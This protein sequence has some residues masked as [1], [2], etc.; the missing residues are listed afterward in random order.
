MASRFRWTRCR[1]NLNR[2]STNLDNL[3]YDSYLDPPKIVICIFAVQLQCISAGSVRLSHSGTIL[4][5]QTGMFVSARP[6]KVV[7]MRSANVHELPSTERRRKASPPPA[8]R[9]PP[10]SR[11]A[12][13]PVRFCVVRDVSGRT[14]TAELFQTREPPHIDGRNLPNFPPL[15]SRRVGGPRAV[16]KTSAAEEGLDNFRLK[17]FWKLSP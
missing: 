6:I 9:P 4:S 2:S 17:L 15:C 16:Q 13:K 11:L 8:T 12:E 1:S 14:T 10:P 5:L 3:H 7:Q